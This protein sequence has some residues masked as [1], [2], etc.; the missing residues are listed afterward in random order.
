MESLFTRLGRI[1]LS[2]LYAAGG[3]S[4][5][6]LLLC[7]LGVLTPAEGAALLQTLLPFSFW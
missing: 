3:I 7:R 1:F 4:G 6:F 5:G 2:L